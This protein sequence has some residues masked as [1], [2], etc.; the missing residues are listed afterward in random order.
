MGNSKETVSFI[1]AAQRLG[2]SAEAVAELVRDGKLKQSKPGRIE[3]DSVYAYSGL[4][5]SGNQTK[6]KPRGRKPS[7]VSIEDAAAYLCVD[8]AEIKRLVEAGELEIVE[9]AKGVRGVRESMMKMY[10]KK[11]EGRE[12]RVIPKEHNDEANK[13]EIPNSVE[14]EAKDG[15]EE[16]APCTEDTASDDKPDIAQDEAACSDTQKEETF[17]LDA[18]MEEFFPGIRRLSEFTR[19]A[20]L[21]TQQK[22]YSRE[23]MKEA[24]ELAY[25]KG[26]LSVY[27]SLMSFERRM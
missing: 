21:A 8:I 14:S 7:V 18:V 16:N 2:I 23:D 27:E 22:R 13:E 20:M 15:E 1:G 26:K 9:G 5:P 17:D 19:K 25:M 24:T 12:E 11:I 3:L 6:D 4:K 10:K